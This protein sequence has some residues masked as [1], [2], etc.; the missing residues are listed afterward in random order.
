MLAPL[1]YTKAVRADSGN[2]LGRV[3][4]RFDRVGARLEKHCSAC[5]L[6]PPTYGSI[7]G[8]VS[9][10]LHLFVDPLQRMPRASVGLTKPI[11]KACLPSAWY[12]PTLLPTTCCGISHLRA[13]PVKSAVSSWRPI[14]A[15]LPRRGPYSVLFLKPDL[16][17]SVLSLDPCS[18][19]RSCW[20]ATRSFSRLPR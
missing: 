11:L 5:A 1:F 14:R 20:R 8:P 9:A 18:P 2:Q 15:C 13:V 6:I 3:G 17:S 12:R 4:L 7:A 19:H 16:A 10:L